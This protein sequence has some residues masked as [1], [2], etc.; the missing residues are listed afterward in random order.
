[1]SYINISNVSKAYAKTQVLKNINLILEKGTQTVIKGASGSGKS[2]L[3]YLL[4]GLEKMEAGSITVA[5]K[6]ISKL[7]DAQ[8]ANYR[9]TEV[10]FIFQFHFLLSSLTCLENILL[11]SRIGEKDIEETKKYALLLAKRLGV[12]ECLVKYPFE[13]SGGQQQRINFIRALSLKPK[14][15]LC[16][17]PTGNLDSQNSKL[18][19]ELLLEISRQNGTTLIIVTH[20]DFIASMFERVVVMKD[21]QL[22]QMPHIV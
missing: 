5:G 6:N 12:E 21:G 13:I 10:G 18:A 22:Q 20:D 14:V 17:E 19:A 3:L 8:L 15:L 1:M 16:D 9:N 2:T 7:S 11:P 4:G